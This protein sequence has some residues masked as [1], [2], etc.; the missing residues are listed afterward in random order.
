MTYNKRKYMSYK[1]YL[2]DNAL[3]PLRDLAHW[4]FGND[5]KSKSDRYGALS[6][7]C[8]LLEMPLIV[9]AFFQFLFGGKL[10]TGIEAGVG[11]TSF[12]ISW[13]Y[14]IAI[15]ITLAVIGKA[16]GSYAE[17]IWFETW[18]GPP[19]PTSKNTDIK[20]KGETE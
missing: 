20:T 19:E 18:Q 14:F 9:I 15:G 12:V 10:P 5:R 13:W 11:Y 4:L 16:T 6:T 17:Y 1:A 3:E 2:K 7:I 8:Y